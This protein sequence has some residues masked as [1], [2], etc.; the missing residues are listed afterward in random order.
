M[1]R[2]RYILL[3]ISLLCFCAEVQAQLIPP[4]GLPYINNFSNKEYN[5]HPQNYAIT[6]DARDFIYV[7]NNHGVLEY[8]GR[9]WELI[10]T[11]KGS[12]VRSLSADESGKMYVG[13]QGEFG[14]LAID[15]IGR[16]HF[17]DLSEG[18][19][20]EHRVFTDVWQTFA[21]PD[22]VYFITIDKVFRYNAD[23]SFK[24][25]SFEEPLLQQPGFYSNGNLF[26]NQRGTGLLRLVDGDF[27][28]VKGGREF[29][30][31]RI[32]MMEEMGDNEVLIG[33]RSRGLYRFDGERIRLFMSEI[34]DYLTD[35]QISGGAKL[36]N[37]IYAIG[38][39]RGGVVLINKDG[40]L[41]NIVNRASDLQDN[42]VRDAVLDQQNGLWLATSSG[43]SRVE[44]FSP[45]TYFTEEVGLRGEIH[46]VVRH[47]GN[48]F[49]GTS[50]GLFEMEL[51]EKSEF[52]DRERNYHASFKEYP[53]LAVDCKDLEEVFGQMLIAT[54]AGLFTIDDSMDLQLLYDGNVNVIY[55]QPGSNRV[56]LGLTNGIALLKYANGTWRE[57]GKAESFDYPITSIIEGP[58]YLW[59]ATAFQ[60]VIQAPAD[61][62]LEELPALRPYTATNGLPN[63]RNIRMYLLERD[64]I[65]ATE[66]GLYKYTG[67]KNFEPANLFGTDK[68]SN[69]LHVQSLLTDNTSSIY[70]PNGQ[71]KIYMVTKEGKGIARPTDKGYFVFDK[72]PLNRI[73]DPNISRIYND[74]AGKYIWLC[75]AESLVQY[76]KT[77]EPSKH[78]DFPTL[79]TQVKLTATDSLLLDGAIATMSTMGGPRLP[80]RQNA[81]RFE[82]TSPSYER[83]GATQYQ[84]TL[85]G[86][87]KVWSEWTEE[88]R[89]DYTNLPEGNF[90][91]R[92]RS[93]DVYGNV[94]EQASY[95][96]TILTPIYRTVGA[97]IFYVVALVLIVWGILAFRSRELRKE[98]EKLASLVKERTQELEKSLVDLKAAQDKMVAQQK[99]ASLGQL[100]A[101]IA[102]EIK[103]PLNFV[104]NFSELS[105]ELIEEIKDEILTDDS[106]DDKAKIEEVEE[107]LTDIESNCKKIAEHGKRADNIV[108][109]MLM[110]SRKENAETESVNINE[111]FEESISFAYRGARGK[112]KDVQVVI[113]KRFDDNLGEMS[114]IKQDVSRVLLN[115]ANNAFYAAYKHKMQNEAIEPKVIFTTKKEVDKAVLT[116]CDNGTG[117]AKPDLEKIF[118]PF[119]TTKPTGE[120]TGLGLSLS[121]D[122]IVKGHG[123]SIDVDSK[124]NEFT[125]F[126]ITLPLQQQPTQGDD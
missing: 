102:H 46:D 61:I 48:I 25:W 103:N 110:H 78:D 111:L 121:F 104:N 115:I 37:G 91:F 27:K 44:V 29:A 28:M 88:T 106:L 77:I 15:S 94:G 13:A 113:E 9:Q 63:E 20:K 3:L 79:L 70:T 71:S 83:Q 42:T 82:F 109:N 93:R 24:V 33:T 16:T 57:I 101:G 67:N 98:K 116:I 1:S 7:A 43:V 35:N 54:S 51:P 21:T 105:V 97:Y 17:V 34:D 117:I 55:Q 49:V 59:I 66:K 39:L 40:E 126:M 120:G 73:P 23:K 62:S 86:S 76:N 112:N 107:I 74:P 41:L 38:T 75:G 123:G 65:F 99:L 96:F 10:R 122:I 2:L 89:K 108:K 64:M 11:M 114:L 58:D 85:D 50:Q 90:V 5:A 92:V 36:T 19:A 22:G 72:K 12:A 30:N 14:Y 95:A 56:W 32:Y 26:V 87:D 45:F 119:F 52:N 60:G 100:T 124:V 81:I 118:E 4:L 80:Y 68:A 47:N 84:F 18:L 8:N 6:C 31:E 125:E 69:D 53:D